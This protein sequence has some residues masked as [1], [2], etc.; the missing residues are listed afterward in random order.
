MRP[1]TS[2]FEGEWAITTASDIIIWGVKQQTILLSWY[3]PFLQHFRGLVIIKQHTTETVST[4]S[5]AF[6][7]NNELLCISLSNRS[8]AVPQ[9]NRQRSA[10]DVETILHSNQTMR[11]F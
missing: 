3:N 8:T 1:Q 5:C 11:Y 6:Q 10:L 9:Y 4:V 2:C 7:T